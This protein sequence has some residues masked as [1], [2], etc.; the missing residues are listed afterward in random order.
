MISSLCLFLVS[1]RQSASY[2][3]NFALSIEPKLRFRLFGEALRAQPVDFP[4]TRQPIVAVFLALQTLDEFVL[5]SGR[6]GDDL[7]LI[8]GEALHAEID[9]LLGHAELL[10]AGAVYLTRE[11]V[12]GDTR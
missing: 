12:F 11:I 5:D 6:F 3:Q 8:G 9:T 10:L 1:E 2:S 4:I 7:P